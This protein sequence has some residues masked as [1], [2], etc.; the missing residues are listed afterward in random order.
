[1]NFQRIEEEKM[2]K[3]VVIRRMEF[4]SKSTAMDN[5]YKVN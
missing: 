5:K 4:C 1:M 2:N 3:L